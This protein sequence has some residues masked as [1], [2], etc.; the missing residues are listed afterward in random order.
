MAQC[1]AAFWHASWVPCCSQWPPSGTVSDDPPKVKLL[2]SSTMT[3]Y[4]AILSAKVIQRPQSNETSGNSENV[5]DFNSEEVDPMDIGHCETGG[6][7]V[8]AP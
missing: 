4:E 2:N 8:L 7:L 5:L 6:N 3:V 1:L